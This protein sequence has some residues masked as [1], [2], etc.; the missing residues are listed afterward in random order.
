MPGVKFPRW[1]HDSERCTS[2]GKV[3]K[4]VSHRINT[5]KEYSFVEARYKCECGRDNGIE[6]STGYVRA[7]QDYLDKK[8]KEETNEATITVPPGPN[9]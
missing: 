3:A 6:L 8:A 4:L 1:I 2:C 5:D 7:Y 9:G